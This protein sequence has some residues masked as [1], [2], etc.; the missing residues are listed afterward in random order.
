MKI[1]PKVLA[2]DFDGTLAES[3]NKKNQ[4]G[5][6]TKRKI[7]QKPLPHTVEFIKKIYAKGW[8]I[9]V[10]SARSWEDYNSIQEWLKK[11]HLNRYITD[12]LCGKFKADIYLDDLSLNV[13]DLH[14]YGLGR[15]FINA[16]IG[17]K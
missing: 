4:V 9:V 8:K 11:Y 15:F 1:Y 16:L 13:R 6:T 3:P 5:Y 14:Y 12:V 2:C 17:K 7:T 10:H